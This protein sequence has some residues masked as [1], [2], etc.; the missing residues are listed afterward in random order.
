MIQI[1]YL[2]KAMTSGIQIPSEIHIS[3][4]IDGLPLF[5]SSKKSLWPIL[6]LISNIKPSV[7]FPIAITCGDGKPQNLDF[8]ARHYK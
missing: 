3:L 7:V 2:N 4:N 5:R 6:G 1:T 8:F